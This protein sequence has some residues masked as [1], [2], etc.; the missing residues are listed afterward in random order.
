MRVN[1]SRSGGICKL[2][3]WVLGLTVLWC[4]VF[5]AIGRW[6]PIRQHIEAMETSG[7]DPSAM[8]YT[9]LDVLDSTI[10]RLENR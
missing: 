10:K 5:P 2:A 1:R 7:I 9:E 4:V 6:R 8:F 3:C